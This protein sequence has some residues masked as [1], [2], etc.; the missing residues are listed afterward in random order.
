VSEF[1][2]QSAD[3]QVTLSGVIDEYA[4][5]S[6]LGSLTG[7]KVV[8]NMRGVRRI[9]S[10]GVRHWMEQI[11]KVPP[12]VT[13]EVIEIPPPIVDQ[14]NMVHGFMGRGKVVSF[15]VPYT[16]GNCE[17][18]R[19]QLVTTA[20]VKKRKGLPEVKCVACG[21]VMEVDDVEEQYLQILKDG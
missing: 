13:M 5:L 21:T 4:D 18:Y 12:N 14:V 6:F 10:Y 16:C 19:E 7:P 3:G 15:Y 8:L 20:E 1:K 9:N 11:R 2:V 17:E